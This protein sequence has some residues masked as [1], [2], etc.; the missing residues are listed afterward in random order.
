MRLSN[1]ALVGLVALFAAG[2]V[3]GAIVYDNTA[4]PTGWLIF[5]PDDVFVG[6]EVTLA[7][8]ARVVTQL[9][10]GLSRQGSPGTADLDARIYANDGPGGEPGTLLWG[11]GLLDDIPLSG[12][13][14]LLS[15]P[16]P[17]VTVPDTIIWAIE[18]SDSKG[19]EQMAVAIVGAEP[20][21]M[22]NIVQAWRGQ[23]GSW[24]GPFPDTV[25]LMARVEAVIPEPST[26][27][28]LTMG[29][30]T[31]TVGWWRRRRAA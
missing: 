6:N 10:I 8:S 2:E 27:V 22:G 12:A 21:T 29:T 18:I 26:L 15:F 4:N 28:L 23:P 30:L 31:L 13:E 14:G 19:A 17:G 11:S 25:P 5:S 16:V 20:P 24:W 7:G 1:I 9:V 3:K